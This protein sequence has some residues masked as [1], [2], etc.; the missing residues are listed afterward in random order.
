MG[1]LMYARRCRGRGENVVAMINLE[2]IGFYSYRHSNVHYPF[3]LNLF[4]PWRADFAAVISDI[5]SRD[6]ARSVARTM[7]R[8]DVRIMRAV[9]PSVLPLVKS[10]DHWAFWRCGY[11]AVMITDTAPL[12][13]RHY[14]RPTDTSEKLDYIKMAEVV[15]G[16]E[17]TIAEIVGSGPPGSPTMLTH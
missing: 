5:E 8:S 2:S 14:H 10:S 1:S 4:S 7:R 13:Y 12:R 15:S 9:L 6:L 11:P 16:L 17:R 3:P